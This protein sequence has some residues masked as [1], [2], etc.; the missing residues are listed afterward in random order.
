MCIDWN[1][2]ECEENSEND[3]S[4]SGDANVATPVSES[5]AVNNVE[6]QPIATSSASEMTVAAIATTSCTT[7]VPNTPLLPVPFGMTSVSAVVTAVS[8]QQSVPASSVVVAGVDLTQLP[9]VQ[10]DLFLRI[11]QQQQ[12]NNAI[13][14]HVAPITTS[15]INDSIG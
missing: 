2:E 4:V 14:E 13:S 12:Q 3:A 7:A 11:H 10:R 9:P 15:A 5:L 8:S 6:V 1:E